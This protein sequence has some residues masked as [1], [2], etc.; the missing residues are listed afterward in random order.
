[1]VH[2]ASSVRSDFVSTHELWSRLRRTRQNP[3]LPVREDSNRRRVYVSALQQAEDLFVAAAEVGYASRPLL[4]FYGLSQA[5]RAIAA[6]SWNANGDTWRL[7]GHGLHTP[8][9]DVDLRD[10]PIYRHG[11]SQ[12]SFRR[13]AAILR[14]PDLPE[15]KS[16]A[17]VTFGDLWSTIPE[18]AERPLWGPN[19]TPALDFEYIETGDSHPLA[20]GIV[21]GHTSA[22][23]GFRYSAPRIRRFHDELSNRKWI[24]H[25][26][27]GSRNRRARLP[28]SGSSYRSPDA[29]ANR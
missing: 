9:L 29:L 16:T 4:I 25:S 24:R 26:S 12:T 7:S 3:P 5:G 10:I 20:S 1:M 13:L 27:L 11:G 23:N 21:M 22:G 6:A 2:H 17:K 18:N 28:L 14:S 8:D 19:E 15:E